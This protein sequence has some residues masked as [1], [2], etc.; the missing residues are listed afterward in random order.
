VQ[1]DSFLL[2][3]A[4]IVRL[5]R[6]HRGGRPAAVDTEAPDDALLPLARNGCH[7]PFVVAALDAEERG[8]GFPGRR[9]TDRPPAVLPC[10]QPGGARYR[11]RLLGVALPAAG[12]ARVLRRDA[13]A[14]RAAP[15]D[16]GARRPGRT[17]RAPV[18]A[19]ADRLGVGNGF[20]A[21]VLDQEHGPLLAAALAGFAEPAGA[22][23]ARPAIDRAVQPGVPCGQPDQVPALGL[24]Q[25]QA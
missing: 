24:G 16:G 21:V 3:P 17:T 23:R 25:Q 4:A 10:A 1:P 8:G 5:R 18:P 6:R 14:R 20:P 13:G 11:D 22:A 12:V 2:P 9:R 19:L 15:A 7:D